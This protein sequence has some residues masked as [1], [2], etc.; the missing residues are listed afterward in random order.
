MLSTLLRV[1]DMALNSEIGSEK[2]QQQCTKPA[3]AQRLPKTCR[4]LEP[5][6]AKHKEAVPNLFLWAKGEGVRQNHQI[7]EAF[8]EKV[9]ST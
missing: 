5:R 4:D 7:Q 9:A 2:G 1:G 8:L 3:R 6:T